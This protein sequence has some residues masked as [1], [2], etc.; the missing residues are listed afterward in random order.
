MPG[1]NAGTG[2]P[3]TLRCTRCKVGRPRGGFDLKA[4]GRTKPIPPHK[5]QGGYRCTNRMI[6]YKCE[7]C[8]HVGW[9]RHSDGE[10]LLKRLADLHD[11]HLTEK[12]RTFCEAW[13]IPLGT[14]S[15]ARLLREVAE[16]ARR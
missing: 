10:R 6:E 14:T 2:Y 9:S 12:A 13:E 16:E 5:P 1:T 7:T 8:G 4:T 15:L 3:L 11:Q